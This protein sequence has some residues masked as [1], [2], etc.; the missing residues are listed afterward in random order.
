MLKQTVEIKNVLHGCGE[1]AVAPMI[2]VKLS[3]AAV[4]FFF[5]IK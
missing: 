4:I 1:L 3:R 5:F 2:P